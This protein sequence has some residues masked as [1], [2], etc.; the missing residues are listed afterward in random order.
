[1][2]RSLDGG[3]TWSV[4]DAF[5]EASMVALG[6]PAPGSDEAAIYVW[7]LRVGGESRACH[8]SID[9]GETWQRLNR[10][11]QRIG[12][13]PQAIAADRAVFGRVFIGTNGSGVW[14][15]EP[16]E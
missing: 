2:Q 15:G 14:Y 7:G 5:A 10:P 8:R 12:N 16:G 6:A 13:A 11:S 1:L 3:V 9:G 4:V